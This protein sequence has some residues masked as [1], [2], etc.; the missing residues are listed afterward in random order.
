MI[1]IHKTTIGIGHLI[2]TRG[3]QQSVFVSSSVHFSNL[4]GLVSIILL[5]QNNESC[6]SDKVR[7]ICFTV[8]TTHYK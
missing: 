3:Q 7:K 2:V 6:W 8:V 5:D 4:T 1:I